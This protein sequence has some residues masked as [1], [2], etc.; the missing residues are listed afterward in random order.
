MY[1]LINTPFKDYNLLSSTENPQ[2]LNRKL[3]NM[4]E[5]AKSLKEMK[6]TNVK[7]E[8]LPVVLLNGVT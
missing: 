6:F 7:P 1:Y 5:K 2:Q 3:F 4:T 8:S